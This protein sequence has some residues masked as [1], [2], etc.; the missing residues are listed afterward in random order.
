MSLMLIRTST[1]EGITIVDLDGRF[2][3]ECAEALYVTVVDLVR[4]GRRAIVLN[5]RGVTAIDAAGLGALARAFGLLRTE[6]G[7]LKLVVDCDEIRQMLIR[8][9]L[10]T[11]V[12][13]FSTAADAFASFD[14]TLTASIMRGYEQQAVGSSL[15]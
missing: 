1:S 7:E 14:E 9:Q 6:G 4:Q 10:V 11:V 15:V 5:L 13:T 12:P 3:V 2:G 8:T